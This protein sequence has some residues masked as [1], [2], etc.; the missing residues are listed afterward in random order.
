MDCKIRQGFKN[1]NQQQIEIME[2]VLYKKELK[3]GKILVSDIKGLHIVVG[4]L[5][6]DPFIVG[7]PYNGTEYVAIDLSGESIG[8]LH[9]TKDHIVNRCI[10]NDVK[11]AVFGQNDYGKA[12]EWMQKNINRYNP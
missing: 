10:V 11:V 2:P 8:G 6:G 7:A 12:L 3:E 5:R 1:I 9:G 4:V